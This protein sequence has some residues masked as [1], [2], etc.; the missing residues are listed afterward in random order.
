MDI[1]GEPLVTE[2]FLTPDGSTVPAVTTAQMRDVDR[3]AIEETGPNLY[4]MMENAGRSL[5]I[6]VLEHLGAGWATDPVV[7]MAGTGGNGGGGIC[8]ARH[9]ANRGVDVTLVV[10][11][12]HGLGAVP[13]DQMSVY[14]ATDGREAEL[15]E[16]AVLEVAVV[17][18]A[19]IGYSVSGAPRG[20][21][22]ELIG[23]TASQPS[24]VIALDVPSGIDATTGDAPGVS[25]SADLTLTLALPKTGLDADGVGELWLADIGIPPEVYRRIGL[26]VPVGLFGPHFRIPLSSSSR[27]G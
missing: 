25:V 23:W 11:D 16:L 17:V 24:P 7:V 14:R 6:T 4:Q 13:A 22:A 5:A 18:D 9:L 2:S 27:A 26:E 21:A 20:M 3:L 10:S 1:P 12:P 19:V 15:D 8:A